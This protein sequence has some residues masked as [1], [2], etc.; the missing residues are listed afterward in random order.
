M[1]GKILITG[2]SG[3]IGSFLV[4]KAVRRGYDV[5]AGIR[6]T[7]SRTFLT[8]SRVRIL[9]LAYT[10]PV[11]LTHQLAAVRGKVGAA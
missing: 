9:P 7:S 2:A 5:V 6:H 4:D 10:S 1:A 3:F 11:E 8:D